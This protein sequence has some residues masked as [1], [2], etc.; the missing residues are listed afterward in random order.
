M[1]ILPLTQLRVER[2]SLISDK[3]F[4]SV[5]A[6]IQGGIGHPKMEK[7]WE[8]IWSADSFQR[9]ESIVKPV[10]GPTGLM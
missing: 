2:L 10:L 1:R 5:L 4:E 3:P 6:A 7:F 9:V 8:E